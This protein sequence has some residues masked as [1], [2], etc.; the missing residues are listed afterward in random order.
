MSPLPIQ[1]GAI[2]AEHPNTVAAV[3]GLAGFA[4]AS[5]LGMG[6]VARRIAGFVYY[7]EKTDEVS[8]Q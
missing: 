6:E 3:L 8:L 7:N 5:M 4:T 1:Q 2:G